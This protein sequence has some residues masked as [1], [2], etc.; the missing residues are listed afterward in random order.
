MPWDEINV[1]KDFTE[2]K[3]PTDMM[4]DI[5]KQAAE[6]SSVIPEVNRVYSH[7]EDIHRTDLPGC[8]RHPTAGAI[9]Q[10]MSWTDPDGTRHNRFTGVGMCAECG[11]QVMDPSLAQVQS[12]ARSE[13]DK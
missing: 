9:Q 1:D 11:A 8:P 7:I 13:Y 2:V 12:I 10:H 4:S 6:Q 5:R 3:D